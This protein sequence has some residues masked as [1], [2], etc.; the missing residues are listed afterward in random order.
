MVSP[1]V[2][3]EVR[4]ENKYKSLKKHLAIVADLKNDI[5]VLETEK[6][7]VYFNLMNG[8]GVY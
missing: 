1:S 3:V 4:L 2:Y 7:F 8:R 5:K 6:R